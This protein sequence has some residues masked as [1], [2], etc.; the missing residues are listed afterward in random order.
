MIR[1]GCRFKKSAVGLAAFLTLVFYLSIS[2]TANAQVTGATLSGTVTDPSGSVI[3]GAEVAI[4]NLGTGIV[5]TVTTDS[6]GLYSAPNLIPGSYE[7]AVTAS[8]FSRAVQTNL[9]LSV[10]QE[11]SLNLALKVGESSQ[12]VTV[13]E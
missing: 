1:S 5:R 9:T 6:A 12:T 7:V 2:S 3:A 11:Q 8:G 4:K 10:G 13:E